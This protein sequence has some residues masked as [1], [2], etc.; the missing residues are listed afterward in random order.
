MRKRLQVE[1]QAFPG[2]AWLLGALLCPV[3]VGGWGV[4]P[5]P[6]AHQP[7]WAGTSPHPP[8]ARWV[9]IYTAAGGSGPASSGLPPALALSLAFLPGLQ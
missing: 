9:G 8:A 5:P 7:S 4:A 3:L 1:G 2:S 6:G